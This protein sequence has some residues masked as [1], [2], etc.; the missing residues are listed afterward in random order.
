MATFV[1]VPGAMCGAWLWQRLVPLLGAAGHEA[2]PLSLTGLGDRSHLIS[3]EIDL[4]T[5][6][7]DLVNL[8]FYEDLY[9][10]ILVGHSYGGLVITGAADR[11]P[12]RIRRLVY[13]DALAPVDGE[14]MVEL[15]PSMRWLASEDEA[16]GL[17][18]PFPVEETRGAIPDLTEEDA[19]WLHARMTPHPKHTRAQP[20]QFRNPDALALPRTYILCIDNWDESLPH[21]IVRA[22]TEPGWD[23]HELDGY[24]VPMVARPRE[25]AD[26]LLSLT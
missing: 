25:L 3:S 22:R 16:A 8:L 14:S 23:F 4:E 26:L 21:D 6:I 1:L 15:R 2:H 11:V 10:A 19:E 18:V 12:E 24:H 17:P 20:V 13:L 9:D 5:H 7:T